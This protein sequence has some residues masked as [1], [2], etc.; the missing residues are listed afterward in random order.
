MHHAGI[1]VTVSID[2]GATGSSKGS[3]SLGGRRGPG[4]TTR[5]LH[6]SDVKILAILG[7]KGAGK[8]TAAQYLAE[9][10]DAKAYALADPLKETL[11]I[12]LGLSQEQLHGTQAQ[13][14]AVDPRYGL[15][16]RQ[17]ME[18][19]G[20]GLRAIFGEDCLVDYTLDAIYRDMPPL[21]I[22]S[23]VRRTNEVEALRCDGALLWRLHYAPAM[24]CGPGTHIS[25]AEWM[26]PEVD[27]EIVPG[28]QGLTELFAALDE[29]CSF[30]GLSS[31]K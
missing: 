8:S 22:V 27:L 24:V 7:G 9:K 18:R 3:W 6:L 10:L 23:D 19:Q 29:A 25:E 13:K 12:E 30:F 14:D 11:C 2:Y 5:M 1:G 15:S 21:A 17:L 31:R 26:K 28:V 4:R 20:D 16:P